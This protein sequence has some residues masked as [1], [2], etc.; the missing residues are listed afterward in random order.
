MNVKYI[1]KRRV[2][3]LLTVL[4]LLLGLLPQAD[5]TAAAERYEAGLSVSS[6]SE[7][8]IIV[9]ETVS[10]SL[11]IS[12][13]S[14]A[15]VQA[16]VA[17]DADAFAYIE[18]AE[19]ADAVFIDA[20]DDEEG[21]VLV[22]RYGAEAAAGTA[23]FTLIF[24]A[25]TEGTASFGAG[26][27]YVSAKGADGSPASEY[28]PTAPEPVSVKVNADPAAP[29][30]G[31][32]DWREADLMI[33]TAEELLAF[34]RDVNG[35][36]KYKDKLVRLGADIDL[37]AYP[38]W[39]GIGN[40]LENYFAGVF[41]G[42]GYDITLAIDIQSTGQV[43]LFGY[44]FGATFRNVT[45]RGSVTN[46]NG[47][48]AG[49]T[50]AL[51]SYA[52][53]CRF[54]NCVNYADVKA[55]GSSV[56]GLA[57]N[58]RYDVRNPD[59]MPV[60][61]VEMVNCF[62]H[63]DVTG[64]SVWGDISTVGSNEPLTSSV[65][66]VAGLALSV[67]RV[68]NCGNT[69]RV[70]GGSYTYGLASLAGTTSASGPY[71]PGGPSDSIAY[72]CYNTGDVTGRGDAA[73][74]LT[75]SAPSR[76]GIVNSYN[77]GDVTQTY[78][79]DGSRTTR[80]GGLTTQ[81]MFSEIHSQSETV[82]N[83]F[84][85]GTVKNSATVKRETFD[86]GN[87]TGYP[88]RYINCY[89][90][91]DK[92]N[93]TAADLGPAFIDGS[94]GYPILAWQVA[95]ARNHEVTFAGLP[96]GGTLTVLNASG[97]LQTAGADGVYSL[98]TGRGYTYTASTGAT[99]G[100]NVTNGPKTI[101][102]T[103][104][105]T[106]TNL[107]ENA[108]L[109][110]LN[111]DDIPQTGADG[112]EGRV[113]LLPNG[114]YT[115]SATN[116]TETVNGA[117]TA[118]GVAR[119]IALP[120]LAA[121]A[122]VSFGVTPQ[123]VGAAVSVKDDAEQT[124]PSESEGVYRLYV[125]QEYTYTVSAQGYTAQS[126][127]FTVSAEGQTIEINLA[128]EIV[129]VTFETSPQNAFVVVTYG[130]EIVEPNSDG[131]YSLYKGET[132]AYVATAS[133]ALADRYDVAEGVFVAN[134]AT[135]N[136]ALPVK[137]GEYAPG[138][139]GYRPSFGVYVL[140]ADGKTGTRIGNW[141]YDKDFYGEDEGTY[142]DEDGE[143]AFIEDFDEP[144]VYSGVDMKPSAR[145]GVV[146][147]G[148]RTDSL[149]AYYNANN[150][151]DYPDIAAD[152]Y[153]LF[154]M[155]ARTNSTASEDPYTSNSP[156]MKGGD[157]NSESATNGL[158][159][160]PGAFDTYS[161][162]KRYYYPAFATGE[163]DWSSRQAAAAKPLGQGTPVPAVIAVTSYDSTI[164]TLPTD[165]IGTDKQINSDTELQAAVDYLVSVADNER[166]L[167][168]FEG[169][170]SDIWSLSASEPGGR[171]LG[172]DGSYYI[173]SVWIAPTYRNIGTDI[174]GAATLELLNVSDGRAA[175]GQT[176][177]LTATPTEPGGTVES[178]RIGE[179]DLA[180]DADGV[181]SFTMPN[182]SVLITVEATG[183]GVS[184]G[185]PPEAP[186]FAEPNGDLFK[187]RAAQDYVLVIEKEFYL[188]DKAAGVT[189]TGPGGVLTLSGDDYTV[190]EGST[191]ATVFASYLNTLPQGDYTLSIAFRD[192][193]IEQ[194]FTIRDNPSYRIEVDPSVSQG[195][196]SASPA[197]A[198]EGE[199][200]V[201]TATPAPG[202]RLA[203]GSLKWD[204]RVVNSDASGKY[205]F[206]M[207]AWHV[208]LTAE[209]IKVETPAVP[210]EQDEDAFKD[211]IRGTGDINA[212][213][214]DGKSIDITWFDPD[215]D[216][217]H[218]KTPSQLAGLA[219]LV[220]GL[221]N[222]EIDT[223]AGKA[224]Y[225]Q[226]NTGLGD[227]SGAKGNNKSTP[228]YHYGKYDF[229]DKTVYLDSDIHM[230]NAN[231]M[232]IGGQYLMRRNDKT[233]RVDASFNGVFDGRG[234][235]VTIS[236]DR[237]E[238]TGNYGDGSSVGLIGRLGNHDNEGARVSGQ[239][240]RNVAVYG[241]VSAN[242]SVG[243]IVGKIGKNIG[244]VVIENCANFADI[245]STDAKGVG[246]IVGAAWNGGVIRNCYNAGT[247]DG[248]H[249]NP[250]GGIAG[251]VE[252][253]IE[254]SYSRGRV[255]APT[256]YAMGIGTNNGGAS[257]P[258]NTYYL[259]DS[260][261]SGGWFTGG[262][263]DNSGMRT[264]T[265]MLSDA[266]VTLLGSAFVKDTN[267][268]NEGYP[269]L[270]WQGG[271]AVTPPASTPDGSRPTVNIPSTTTV[272]DGEAVTVIDIP[273][274]CLALADS[275]SSRLIVNVDTG[276]ESVSKI[277]AEMPAEF[278]KQASESNSEIEVRSDVANVLLPE[279]AVTELAKAG[280]DVSVKA[281]KNEE[282]NTYIF[283]VESDGKALA[284][285]DGGI[286]AAI[287]VNDASVGMVAVLVHEDGTEELIKKSA[288]V[289]GNLL[290]PLSGSATVKIE[291]RSKSFD[292]VAAGVW[293]A[294]AVKF[295]S[296]RELFQ[297]TTES[298]FSPNDSMTRAML[299]TVL[300]RLE[301]EPETAVGDIFSD[302]S[303]TGYYARAVAWA[304][305]NGIVEGVG[306]GLF[307]P[308]AEITREQLAAMLYR[309]A[310]AQGLDVSARGELSSF[311]DAK[312]VSSWAS[313]ALSWAVGAGIITGRSNPVGT[314]LAPKDT[315]TR[316]EVA[317]IIMRM[318]ER[319]AKI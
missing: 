309:C 251:S 111:A 220:N 157:W 312:D 52:L 281:E 267:K 62:N 88:D 310:S 284:A 59:Y 201:V 198:A 224:S 140:N 258:V 274:E 265:Y 39:P 80:A 171:P 134:S 292:D 141:L 282:A 61:E 146:L 159:P 244:G 261:A 167:R 193:V 72:G 275:P 7:E 168:N 79:G 138:W 73:A 313:E 181:Y 93:F 217:Y 83:S 63:G 77:A 254:N 55:N 26:A 4:A 255:T 257:T 36:N 47:S 294:D 82:K 147:K 314:E 91:A 60:L 46:L 78:P 179:T 242:R 272:K 5:F 246:G 209:F 206:V 162:T 158:W 248:K 16:T 131:T 144:L 199:T 234:H 176:V 153:A 241:S 263:A 163:N 230:G 106:F 114:A 33:Y 116:G 48:G 264:S 235:S 15:A 139:A 143:A 65:Y 20:T 175:V 227:D 239:A 127:A 112:A 133:G 204:G 202:Y 58:A 94:D 3:P 229:A 207:P 238:S 54:T 9:G 290:V 12:G 148:I 298:T 190:E 30:I 21:E 24:R 296:S 232:P 285:L 18:P 44:S 226:V 307:A 29:T 129:T 317:A 273:E 192:T 1:T 297:G 68:I 113:Y 200:V 130:D 42:D 156:S 124:V 315:A 135:V 194:G 187:T 197:N 287:P 17:Y 37:T 76:Y 118:I 166:A 96:E 154:D 50:S 64:V 152:N 98:P 110:V 213:V 172:G 149:I 126:A 289:D 86:V 43:G 183:E 92:G 132:Y 117:F 35:G 71:D 87:M 293:Y 219:A 271:S 245:S 295:V 165:A 150:D 125:G 182:E 302:V 259:E 164:N 155:K 136:V 308:N 81:H 151:A 185:E 25:R 311:M 300:Y 53:S 211:G 180:A 306:G 237:L 299:V 247:V 286:K 13:A 253:L 100:F 69:G 319:A 186:A 260:A 97:A 101:A 177:K 66:N 316:A 250:A 173:G 231:Y 40:S 31:V 277:T 122:Y 160:L 119:T 243:G 249:P 283:T 195:S 70:S 233:T 89:T 123:D 262:S 84:N 218:I 10:V 38:D 216:T 103:S 128:R 240:V 178:V 252:I 85:V 269:V 120:A 32:D 137:P 318:I 196:V 222:R 210:P 27:V 11:D 109:T 303:V 191:V 107:P 301:N 28:E 108:T 228:T 41:D 214:W 49:H 170:R 102:L 2:L 161:G 8:E 142:I 121:R 304:S 14:Y 67:S 288:T 56:S 278:M 105:V 75:G 256:G 45:T 280:K 305:E 74:G 268:I 145:L 104:E 6:V 188:Y 215:A 225:I 189:L 169:M 223:V 279:K 99:G 19:P 203:P 23:A 205:S 276:E 184:P 236:L 115:Y 212:A 221:Y 208:T 22:T 51:A 270:S 174:D 95:P 57:G 90:S 266:F 34:A 291:D